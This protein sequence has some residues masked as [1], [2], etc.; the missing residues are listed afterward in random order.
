MTNLA[1][2]LQ[3]RC[4]VLCKG[5]LLLT[6][7]GG[8]RWNGDEHNDKNRCKTTE[9]FHGATPPKRFFA[10]YQCGHDTAVGL[11]NQKIE[12][13]FGPDSSLTSTVVVMMAAASIPEVV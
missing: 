5:H 10:I 11:A 13:R 4:D 12:S 3:D 2:A 9:G 6:R 7:L 8:H 1:T